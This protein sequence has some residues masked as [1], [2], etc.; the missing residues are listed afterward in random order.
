MRKFSETATIVGRR[1]SAKRRKMPSRAHGDIRALA[2][3]R[4]SALTVA[5][6]EG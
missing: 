6:F 5:V 2:A 4:P 1:P 3:L